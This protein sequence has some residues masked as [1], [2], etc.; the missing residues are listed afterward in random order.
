M[1]TAVRDYCLG[2]TFTEIKKS[3]EDDELLS[4]VARVSKRGLT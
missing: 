4:D 3:P 1:E 2:K